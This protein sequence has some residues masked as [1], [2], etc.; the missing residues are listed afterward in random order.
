M[1]TITSC[2]TASVKSQ[3]E[4]ANLHTKYSH[5]S[6]QNEELIKTAQNIF[7][8][9]TELSKTDLTIQGKLD[10]EDFDLKNKLA[11]YGSVYADLL[12]R[13]NKKEQTK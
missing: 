3:I 7:D 2:I 12:S 4:N 10:D 5:L 8:K 1:T 6:S 11:E 13:K 9:I